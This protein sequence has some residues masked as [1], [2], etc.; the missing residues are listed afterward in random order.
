[1]KPRLHFPLFSCKCLRYAVVHEAITPFRMDFVLP[2]NFLYLWGRLS[3]F[4]FLFCGDGAI[5]SVK[6]PH[7]RQD[8]AFGWGGVEVAGSNL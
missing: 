5:S 8:S 7:I 1:M 3:V 4:C 6:L 2:T